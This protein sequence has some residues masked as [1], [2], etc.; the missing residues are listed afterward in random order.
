MAWILKVL[1]ASKG[2]IP[3]PAYEKRVR[4]NFCR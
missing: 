4:A 2:K 3:V 1:E